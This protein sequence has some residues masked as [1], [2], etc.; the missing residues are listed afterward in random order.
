MIMDG[1]Q[2]VFGHEARDHLV[3]GINILADAVGVT[4]GPKG[5]VVMLGQSFGAPRVTKDG[6]SVAKDI[7]LKHPLQDM[8]AQTLREVA[9][10]TSD[11]AGDGTTTATVLARA[12]VTEGMKAVVAGVNPIDFKRG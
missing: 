8:G 3:A 12:I 1:K 9:S 2:I 5:R 11:D 6:V 10:Q 4:M 7:K